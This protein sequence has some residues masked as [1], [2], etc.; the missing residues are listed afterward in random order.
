[1]LICWELHND[2]SPGL[3]V[4]SVYKHS[5]FSST[6][7]GII[8]IIGQYVLLQASINSIHGSLEKQQV[9][10]GQV[11]VWTVLLQRTPE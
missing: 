1:M 10:K 8:I 2:N 7:Q 6:Y 5:T 4:Q 9:G 11:L 3:D